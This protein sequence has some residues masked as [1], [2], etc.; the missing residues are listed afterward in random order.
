MRIS[1]A[2]DIIIVDLRNCAGVM[3]VDKCDL[4]VCSD[5]HYDPVC[6]VN[7]KGKTMWFAS[8]C[9]LQYYNCHHH[10]NATELGTRITFFSFFLVSS[11]LFCLLFSLIHDS[12]FFPHII[13]CTNVQEK[14]MKIIN[15]SSLL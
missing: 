9:V 5:Y 7:N 1:F 14:H 11:V 13:Q 10:G 2:D 15:I 3:P 4:L 6:G 12:T 8:A